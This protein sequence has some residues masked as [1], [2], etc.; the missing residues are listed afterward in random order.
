MTFKLRLVNKTEY[1]TKEMRGLVGG[2][3]KLKLPRVRIVVVHDS[4]FPTAR[5]YHKRENRHYQ[6]KLLMPRPNT[7]PHTMLH[8]IDGHWERRVQN[9]RNWRELFLAWS[10]H[11]LRHVWQLSH[12]WSIDTITAIHWQGVDNSKSERDAAKYAHKRL[13]AYQNKER[14]NETSREA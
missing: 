14:N 1:P 9:L 8:F 10:A 11:E 13:L 5:M 7:Y 6:V 12:G 4:L 3:I 2:Y